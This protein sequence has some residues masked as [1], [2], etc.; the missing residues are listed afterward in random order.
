MRF[1]LM[2]VRVV[3][4][5]TSL[6]LLF[7]S[8]SALIANHVLKRQINARMEHL[9]IPNSNKALSFQLGLAFFY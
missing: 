2:R 4:K 6:F 8:T 3:H 7:R 5:S 1:T 9:I